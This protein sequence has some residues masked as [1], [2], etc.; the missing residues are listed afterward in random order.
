MALYNFHRVLIAA[1][2]LFDAGYTLFSINRWQ[3]N[4]NNLDLVMA[5]GSTVVTIG[6]VLYLIYFNRKTQRISGIL[7]GICD[8]CGADVRVGIEAGD[9][10]CGRCGQPLVSPDQS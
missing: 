10:L 2:I 3:A 8:S 7:R 1:A 5:I 9:P 6:F 4:G